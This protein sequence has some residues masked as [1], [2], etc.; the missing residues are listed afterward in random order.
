MTH[1]VIDRDQRLAQSQRHAFGGGQAHHHPADQ[2]GSGRRRHPVNVIAPDMGLV[3]GAGDHRIQDLQMGAA[4]DFR[5]HAA[6][7]RMGSDLAGD[8]T[9]KDGSRSRRQPAHHRSRGFIA[10]GLDPQ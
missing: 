6:I 3:Q 9:G 8:D 1:Q 2:A 7:G 5:H 4:G 10:A